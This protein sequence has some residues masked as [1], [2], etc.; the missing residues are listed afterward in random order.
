MHG[1]ANSEP[2]LATNGDANFESYCRPNNHPDQ[3]PHG[4][5]KRHANGIANFES[6]CRPNN[7]P[8]QWPY[9]HA[10]GIANFE[11]YCESHNVAHGYTH[12]G[13]HIYP[14][15]QRVQ[16]W[17]VHCEQVWGRVCKLLT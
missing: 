12:G 17:I 2:D 5:A 1:G 8:D 4:H 9:G 14:N 13:A 6:Y 7:H 16:T 11:S 10:N 15:A 3:W